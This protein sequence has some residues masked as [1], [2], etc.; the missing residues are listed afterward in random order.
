MIIAAQLI[1]PELIDDYE[2]QIFTDDIKDENL[3]K[4]YQTILNT[5]HNEDTAIS[6][7]DFQ[8]LIYQNHPSCGIKDLWQLEM[9][10]KRNPFINELKKL[11]E[12]LLA[13]NKLRTL[14]EEIKNL[15]LSLCQ[16]FSEED[17]IRQ[18]ALKQERNEIVSKYS[19]L[20]E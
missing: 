1:Y 20:D 12:K 11:I 18:N 17:Y 6:G 16:N 5:Y 10:K 4:L 2:E 13:E 3:K 14:D 8:N 9:L 15:S 7:E 19:N